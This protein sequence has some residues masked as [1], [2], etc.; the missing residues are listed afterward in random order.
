MYK[1]WLSKIIVKNF[2]FFFEHPWRIFS[3]VIS[4]AAHIPSLKRLRKTFGTCKGRIEGIFIFY[5]IF[6]VLSKL[7]GRPLHIYFVYMF[8]IYLTL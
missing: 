4:Q 8:L 3:D 2:F 5:D 1:L 7:T 6:S